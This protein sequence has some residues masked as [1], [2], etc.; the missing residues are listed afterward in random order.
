MLLITSSGLFAA[1]GDHVW[2]LASESEAGRVRGSS[3]FIWTGESN[4]CLLV[5]GLVVWQCCCVHAVV[6]WLSWVMSAAETKCSSP[7]LRQSGASQLLC[8]Y[9]TELHLQQDLRLNWTLNLILNT[10]ETE[11]TASRCILCLLLWF[12]SG[13]TCGGRCWYA[14]LSACSVVCLKGRGHFT[15]V[16]LIFLPCTLL[17]FYWG[18]RQKVSSPSCIFVATVYP[19]IVFNVI[20]KHLLFALVVVFNI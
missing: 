3:A 12:S 19:F 20:V 8:F 6:V 5:W 2:V 1:S 9:S 15:A 13:T 10:C 7:V 11:P 14:P 16:G 4:Q 18:L 17:C